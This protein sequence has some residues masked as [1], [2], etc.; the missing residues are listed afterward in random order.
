MTSKHTPLPAAALPSRSPITNKKSPSIAC[1]RWKNTATKPKTP[2]SS[3]AHGEK[4]RALKLE[5]QQ[6]RGGN[7]ASKNLKRG[8]AEQKSR[9]LDWRGS[10][11]RIRIL[12]SSTRFRGLKGIIKRGRG[13]GIVEE[14]AR[15]RMERVRLEEEVTTIR[16]E[17]EVRRVKL[18]EEITK[19][20][21]E[22][23]KLEGEVLANLM[24]AQVLARGRDNKGVEG[25]RLEREA[26]KIMMEARVLAQENVDRVAE[27]QRLM[28]EVDRVRA[29][30]EILE[31]VRQEHGLR[32]E[33][34]VRQEHRLR[35]EKMVRLRQEEMMGVWG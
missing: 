21:M 13:L 33:K 35:W 15:A 3:T 25:V 7:R 26:D 1:S 29:E 5:K 30:K 17:R 6:P 10:A 22:R 16:M 14:I 23:V 18:N 2:P 31:M 28:E 11:T 20:R 4:K 19:M 32:W 24:E 27:G 34:M 12:S 9:V 8:P